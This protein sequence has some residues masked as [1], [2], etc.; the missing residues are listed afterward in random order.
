M[1]CPLVM[2]TWEDS[3]RP[4]PAWEWLSEF[5]AS[6]IVTIRSVGWLIHDDEKS[7]ALAPNLGGHDDDA[8]QVSGIIEI[9]DRAVIKV[10]KLMEDKSDA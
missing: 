3:L 9:P 6:N 7:K 2:I 5:Q 10:E 1:T 8:M 4:R